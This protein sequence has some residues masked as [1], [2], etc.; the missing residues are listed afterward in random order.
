M[1][2]KVHKSEKENNKL[3]VARFCST[4]LEIE[5]QERERG[6]ADVILSLSVVSSF[7]RIPF[8][9]VFWFHLY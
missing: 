1:H 7:W 5:Q 8:F 3:F 9:S 6:V 2:M 4:I